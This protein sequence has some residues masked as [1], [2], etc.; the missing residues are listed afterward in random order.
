MSQKNMPLH[1]SSHCLQGSW[2]S[3]DSYMRATNRTIFDEQQ[4]DW[5]ALHT[6]LQNTRTTCLHSWRKRRTDHDRDPILVWV[7]NFIKKDPLWLEPFRDS[8]N[9][10]KSSF[11]TIW[12][13]PISPCSDPSS[14]FLTFRNTYWSSLSSFECKGGICA[15]HDTSFSIS[16]HDTIMNKNIAVRAC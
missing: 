2:M 1:Y 6:R 12:A 10:K 5:C 14:I 13:Q 15:P 3:A 7:Q 4:F 16:L 11:R 8:K 9:L